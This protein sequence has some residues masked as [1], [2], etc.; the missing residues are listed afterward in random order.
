VEVD[1]RVLRGINIFLVP[2]RYK[3]DFTMTAGSRPAN[4]FDKPLNNGW[5]KRL[6]EILYRDEREWT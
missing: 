3:S 1:L 6:Q 4:S 2:P 5:L